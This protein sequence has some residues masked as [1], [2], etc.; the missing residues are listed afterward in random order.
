MRNVSNSN[1]SDEI[2]SDEEDIN[3]QPEQPYCSSNYSLQSL[4]K[5][6]SIDSMSSMSDFMQ[7]SSMDSSISDLTQPEQPCCSGDYSS[8]NLHKSEF[9]DSNSTSSMSDFVQSSSLSSRISYLKQIDCSFVDVDPNIIYNLIYSIH[10]KNLPLYMSSVHLFLESCIH[11]SLRYLR[12]FKVEPL[13]SSEK[14]DLDPSPNRDKY[15]VSNEGEYGLLQYMCDYFKYYML[16]NCIEVVSPTNEFTFSCIEE[17]DYVKIINSIK[18]KTNVNKCYGHAAKYGPT[19]EVPTL[20]TDYRILYTRN[21]HSLKLS[22]VIR[23]RMSNYL[24][25]RR[26]KKSVGIYREETGILIRDSYKIYTVRFKN[27]GN[28]SASD[29]ILRNISSD[30]KEKIGKDI[31]THKSDGNSTY[32]IPHRSFNFISGINISP[33]ITNVDPELVSHGDVADII[34]SLENKDVSKY[35][36]AMN[37]FTAKFM[38]K[39]LQYI[40]AL[41]VDLHNY[42]DSYLINPNTDEYIAQSRGIYTKLHYICDYFKYYV[43]GSHLEFFAYDDVNVEEKI[44]PLLTSIDTKKVKLELQT[45][46]KAEEVSVA[47]DDE[48][49]ILIESV[50]KE[51]LDL[52]ENRKK[53]ITEINDH[54][55]KIRS[56]IRP[57]DLSIRDE[58]IKCL[59]EYYLS[60]VD[61]FESMAEEEFK[62]ISRPINERLVLPVPQAIAEV[63]HREIHTGQT[64]YNYYVRC[65]SNFFCEGN[66]CLCTRSRLC[67]T[68]TVIRIHILEKVIYRMKEYLLSLTIKENG[69]IIHNSTQLFW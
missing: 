11:K 56:L 15:I 23:N 22:I 61:K 37:S 55:T 16:E 66:T 54:K 59:M 38:C 46:I 24:S 33:G 32:K 47:I 53:L 13:T 42:D 58:L 49:E 34:L 29:S 30:E 68:S 1:F 69:E 8:Q 64:L 19:V 18:D 57:L 20:G 21:G 14:I 41:K 7:S 2:V 48:Y 43:L 67:D 31:I 12:L 52:K 25:K 40:R 51:C 26:H 35:L 60:I 5:S 9:I 45:G 62:N 65:R 27:M 28:V 36:A 44:S 39:S 6:E 17:N 10:S 3:Y 50:R 4:H 63:A